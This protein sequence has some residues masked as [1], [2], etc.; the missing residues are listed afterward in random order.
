MSWVKEQNKKSALI[1]KNPLYGSI[2]AD[3]HE[4]FLAKDRVPLPGRVANHFIYNFWQ[5]PSHMRG[6]WRRANEKSYRQINPK[7]QTLL[8]L[9]ELAKQ[10]NENWVWKDAHCLPPLNNR[11]LV[12]LSRGEKDAATVREFDLDHSEFIKDRF[13][14]G[15]AKSNI[16]WL[17]ENTVWVGTDFGP[18]SM[19]RS[20]YHRIVKLWKRGIPLNEAN[21]IFVGLKD[22]S[23]GDMNVEGYSVFS[24]NSRAVNVITRVIIFFETEHYIY[25]SETNKLHRVKIPSSADFKGVFRNYV[26]ASCWHLDRNS[27]H[28][29]RK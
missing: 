9:D 26:F 15:E 10:E 23:S 24:D 1:E 16:H 13:T 25:L 28:F 18:G 6:I 4:I 7:W 17:G 5:E 21:I 2:F 22:L 14:L 12:M 29:N 27:T 8:D 11:C 19:T 3:I 20:G